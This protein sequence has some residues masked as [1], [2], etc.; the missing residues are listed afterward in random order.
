[1]IFSRI[2]TALLCVA[3]IGSRALWPQGTVP[4]APHAVADTLAAITDAAALD[5]L[6]AAAPTLPDSLAQLRAGAILVR[7]GELTH[8]R[9]PLDEALRRFAA[10]AEAHPRWPVPWIALGRA[11]LALFDGG[12]RPKEGPYQRLG[13]D[14]L[15]GAGAAFLR[16]LAADSGN[17]TAASLL[18]ATVLRET[19]Q[20]QTDAALP[21]LRRAAATHPTPG[22]LLPL[23]MLERQDGADS[24]A[25]AAFRQYLAVGG[26]SGIG[27]IELATT[28]FKLGQRTEAESLYYAGAAEA[29]EAAVRERYRSDLT[30]VTTPAELAAFDSLSGDSVAPWLRHFWEERDAREGRH[31]GDRLAEHYRR[32]AYALANFRTTL[33]PGQQRG[34]SWGTDADATAATAGARTMGRGGETEGSLLNRPAGGPAR[35][36]LA[37]RDAGPGGGTIGVESISA[38]TLY[39]GLASQ[40]LLAAYRETQSLIDDRGVVYLRYGEP[41]QRAFAVDEKLGGNESWKYLTPSGSLILHFSGA[42]A[43]NHLIDRVPMYLPWLRSRGTLDPE[44]DRLAFELWSSGKALGSAIKPEHVLEVNQE[45]E[46]AISVA[47]TSDAFPLAFDS[48]LDAATQAYGLAQLPGAGTGALVTFALR[49]RHLASRHDQPTGLTVYPVRLRVLA[50]R[51]DATGD[52]IEHDSLRAFA[53]R[54]PLTNEQYLTGQSIVPL[55]PGRYAVRVVLADTTGRDGVALFADTVAVPA[56]GGPH[57]TLSDVVLGRERSTQTITIGGARVPLDPLGT[58]PA[59][60]TITLYYQAGGLTP[61]ATY[62]AQ[63]EV[64]RRFGAT[65][66][67]RLAVAFQDRAEGRT[68]SYRRTIDLKRL[69]PGAYDVRLTLKGADGA[70]VERRRKLNVVK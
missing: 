14:Y 48:R 56:L 54:T 45:T 8:D 66:K 34:M 37:N 63:I 41:N 47:T 65:D 64:R 1:M 3:V 10:V 39:A 57:L 31:L 40:S 68:A 26:D 29:G 21:A 25:A 13:A 38:A 19:V 60:G 61:G 2:A 6:P 7:R 20:P 55:A 23:G 36:L 30:W 67:D 24:A 4:S 33:E 16:A 27:D 12:F 50:E 70:T 53:A 44:Y 42:V 9:T 59:D 58:V 69:R 11:K 49:A 32:L 52:V 17:A 35:E 28:L 51:L 43:P 5:R 18:G 62:Q 22:T 15:Q 46:H